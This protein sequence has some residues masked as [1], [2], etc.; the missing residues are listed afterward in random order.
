V[1]LIGNPFIGHDEQKKKIITKFISQ[2]QNLR[3]KILHLI[4]APPIRNFREFHVPV[5]VQSIMVSPIKGTP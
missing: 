1:L 3:H 4:K 5:G 2:Q